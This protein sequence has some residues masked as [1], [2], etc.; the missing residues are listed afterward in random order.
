MTTAEWFAGCE[1]H[2]QKECEHKLYEQFAVEGVIPKAV[3]E[4]YDLEMTH[5]LENGFVY[6]FVVAHRV[7]DL[8][9]DCGL[10]ALI[11]GNVAYSLLSFLYGL[12]WVNPVERDYLPSFLMGERFD[13]TMFFPLVVSPDFRIRLIRYFAETL[14]DVRFTD[15]GIGIEET[16]HL[17]VASMENTIDFPIRTEWLLTLAEYLDREGAPRWVPGSINPDRCKKNVSDNL[18][19]H[20]EFANYIDSDVW[21]NKDAVC[22]YFQLK[23]SYRTLLDAVGAGMGKKVWQAYKKSGI[24]LFTHDALYRY[25]LLIGVES[26]TAFNIADRVRKGRP[27]D[28]QIRSV[29]S[30]LKDPS[31]EMHLKSIEYLV[32]DGACE[33]Y[34]QLILYMNFVKE[35]TPA[36]YE[37]CLIRVSRRRNGISEDVPGYIDLNANPE[38]DADRKRLGITIM[39]ESRVCISKVPARFAGY[40]ADPRCLKRIGRSRASF[41]YRYCPEADGEAFIIKMSDRK[42]PWTFWNIESE[43][44]TLQLLQDMPYVVKLH[45]SAVS[46]DCYRAC[47]LEEE[48]E[49]LSQRDFSDPGKIFALGVKLCEIFTDLRNTG[50]AYN[51]ISP[52][53]IM[54]RKDSDYPVLADFNCATPVDKPPV[55]IVGT[56]FYIAPEILKKIIPWYFPYDDAPTIRPPYDEEDQ[57]VLNENIRKAYE[58]PSEIDVFFGTYPSLGRAVNMN[59]SKRFNSF[60]EFKE[61]MLKKELKSFNDM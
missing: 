59:Q 38:L 5:V 10:Q 14:D 25:L 21:E 44:E 27:A 15:E 58:E 51:D 19:I 23:P 47:L 61:S 40:F 34:A 17:Q 54:F 1:E 22:D 20:F 11:G 8:A 49:P 28:G 6:S 41:L 46:Y 26:H 36:V 29:I 50:I 30:Q 55:D 52:Q 18:K 56:P 2:F 3:R 24:P 7:L 16:I 57:K 12:T 32:S 42:R 53:N 9:K 45:D 31:L 4:R 48:L 39:D 35:L 13:R 37:K 43:S 60:A 33:L